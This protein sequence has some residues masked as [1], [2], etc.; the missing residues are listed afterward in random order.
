MAR[1]T[2]A[3]RG[4]A[5]GPLRATA[6]VSGAAARLV[7]AAR[8]VRDD[9]QAEAYEALRRVALSW[10]RVRRALVAAGAELEPLEYVDAAFGAALRAERRRH[11]RARGD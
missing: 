1:T 3:P 5:F 10:L 7:R 6:G 8:P 9:E 11:I 2:R 4:M